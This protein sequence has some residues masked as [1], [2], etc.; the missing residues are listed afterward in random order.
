M[1]SQSTK[2]KKRIFLDYASATPL[3]RKVFQTMKPFFSDSYANPSTLYA[4]GLGARRAL[5]KARR[6]VADLLSVHPDEIVFTG[7]GTESANSAIYGITEEF[8]NKNKKAHIIV[9]PFEHPAVLEA[10]KD[11]ESKGGRVTYLPVSSSGCIDPVDVRKALTPETILVSV[12]YANNEIGTIQP[13]REIAKVIRI[14]R[15]N[16]KKENSFPYFY[17]DASQAANYLPLGVPQLGVDLM[18]LDGSKIYGP[19]GVGILYVRRGLLL[20]PLIVG[21]KQEEGR[22][23]GTEN[24][25]AIVGFSRALSITCIMR[26]Q[27]NKRLTALRDKCIHSIMK[28]IPN[29]HLNGS[30]D[31]RLANNINICFPGID[32]EFLVLQLDA[33]GIAV[34]ASSSCSNLS[35]DTRSHTIIALGNKGC[36]ESSLRISL[37]RFTT[38]EDIKYCVKILERLIVFAQR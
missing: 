13:I 17:T 7:S 33:Q 38:N 20:K 14:F 8:K 3:D 27:E 32:A 37:G 21:G 29:A 1:A 30:L 23:A 24:V 9:S 34:S 26:D 22:R 31:L 2:N 25:P 36:E 5:N 19:K 18:T 28:K 12:M 35:L 10:V 4:E 16:K 6:L 15:K 11:F